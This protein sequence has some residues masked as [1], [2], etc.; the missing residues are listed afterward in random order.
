MAAVRINGI[1]YDSLASDPSTPVEGQRWFN[2]TS[3]RAKFYQGGVTRVLGTKEELDTHE[4]TANPHGTTLENAR[5][6]GDTLA[7]DIDMGGNKIVNTSSGTAANDVATNAKVD[8]K[9]RAQVSGVSWKQAV[10]DKDVLD[11]TPLTPSAGDRYLIAGTGAGAWAGKDNNIAEWD[12][13][14]WFYDDPTAGDV[15]RVN[16]EPAESRW[17]MYGGAT[18]G[19]W[20]PSLSH[21]LLDDLDV[22]ADHPNYLDLAGT[23]PLTGNLDAGGND[24]TNVGLVDG[25]AV[26]DHDARH[27]RA[28]ADEIDGDHLGID[29]TPANY[30]PDT[31]PAEADHVDDLAAHLKGIDD[32]LAVPSGLATK[33]GVVLT[34]AFGGN[35][36][37]ATVSFST[38][39]ADNNYSISLS[40]E[41]DAFVPHYEN[42]S[43]AGFD[44]NLNVNNIG[45]ALVGVSWIAV[46]HGET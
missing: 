16:D 42:K 18:W 46:K 36:K 19:E 27:E 30:T 1:I 26:S 15:V 11:P 34:A 24:V 31:T 12:G 35:P 21:S 17:W 4:G 9:I 8:E 7:G 20:N 13:A 43:N 37:V 40:C 10:L 22:T 2:S 33:A 41:A 29:F 45:G 38:A 44:I 3:G 32:E 28:G 5:S 25:V 39:F 14:A 23:R 6:A